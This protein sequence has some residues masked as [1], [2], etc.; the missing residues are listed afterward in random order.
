[1]T[2]LH[3]PVTAFALKC[4]RKA[5]NTCCKVKC[6]RVPYAAKSNCLTA[7]RMPCAACASS[8]PCFAPS[9]ASAGKAFEYRGCRV[10]LSLGF[11]EGIPGRA[12][13][14]AL[15]HKC[16]EFDAW[17]R[18]IPRSKHQTRVTKSRRCQVHCMG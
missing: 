3:S 13:N 4:Y 8:M 15:A 17:D 1:M 12:H 2:A 10:R 11:P 14:R 18:L 7:S 16:H 6:F 5:T 9:A